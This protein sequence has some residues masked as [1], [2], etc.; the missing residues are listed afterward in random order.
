MAIL[1]KL[2]SGFGTE[3]R[4][5]AFGSAA[6]RLMRAFATQLRYFD[7]CVTAGA[8]LSAS[9]TSM[10][11][12][13]VRPLSAMCKSRIQRRKQ[14]PDRFLETSER[15]VAKTV[16][17]TGPPFERRAG[18]VFILVFGVA[19]GAIL[20]LRQYAVFGLLRVILVVAVGAIRSASRAVMARGRLY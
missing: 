9:S 1:A 4:I 8:N 5:A 16:R 7:A 14:Q 20:G 17:L 2:D 19:A 15:V 10:S 12:M 3:R 6:A 11:T 13:E 18:M